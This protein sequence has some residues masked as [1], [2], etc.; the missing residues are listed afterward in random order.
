[1]KIKDFLALK[2]SDFVFILLA[3]VKMPMIAAVVIFDIY[4]EQDIYMPSCMKKVLLP[5]SQL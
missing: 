5:Q 3:Y 4:D 1:M 2:L